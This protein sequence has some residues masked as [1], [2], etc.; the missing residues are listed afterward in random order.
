MRSAARWTPAGSGLGGTSSSRDRMTRKSA[1][2]TAWKLANATSTASR[3]LRVSIPSV[4]P[5]WR[6]AWM[7]D[8]AP[9]L[10]RD[11]RA[12]SS[13]M[14]SST[15]WARRRASCSGSDSMNSRMGTPDRQPTMRRM[16]LKSRAPGTVSVPS[17]SNRMPRMGVMLSPRSPGRQADRRPGQRLMPGG[18]IARFR[19]GRDGRAPTDR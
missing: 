14:S 13:S 3:A 19:R 11:C 4:K 10:G 16:R 2:V 1:A 15:W 7:T 5:A 18:R 9:S 12:A 17:K 8:S 6:H